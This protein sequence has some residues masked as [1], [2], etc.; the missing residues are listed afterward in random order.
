ML[1][2]TKIQEIVFRSLASSHTPLLPNYTP[3]GWFECDLFS[4]TKA[5]FFHEHEIKLTVSDFLRDAGKKAWSR[6]PDTRKLTRI[7]KHERLAAADARGPACFWYVVP[8]EIVD[9]FAIPAFAGLKIITRYRHGLLTKKPAPRLHECKIES[10]ITTHAYSVCY[11][12]FWQE[13]L[14]NAKLRGIK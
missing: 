12:R 13:R 4:V 1:T 8:E 6:D 7:S 14:K 5:G 3:R 9:R 11:W 10:R 2:E